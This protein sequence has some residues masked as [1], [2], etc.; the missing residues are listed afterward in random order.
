MSRGHASVQGRRR[1]AARTRSS[2]TRTSS[3]TRRGCPVPGAS[4]RCPGL[5]SEDAMPS[6]ASVWTSA[7]IVRNTL[8][9][10]TKVSVLNTRASTTR[11]QL[12][13][14]NSPAGSPATGPR[15]CARTSSTPTRARVR[16]RGGGRLPRHHG[17]VRRGRRQE[18]PTQADPVAGAVLAREAPLDEHGLAPV[19]LPK[20]ATGVLGRRSHLGRSGRGLAPAQRA[21]QS[22]FS[23]RACDAGCPASGR[24]AL[25]TC[26][27]AGL[28]RNTSSSSPRVRAVSQ[29][30]RAS[31]VAMSRV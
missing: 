6:R 24:N 9:I 4:T 20:E 10:E 18:D 30:R 11:S 17:V 26:R 1:P 21:A 15:T 23:A 19:R 22:T 27:Y 16:A 14:F 7:R 29:A 31:V 5:D 2:S 25:R 3:T 13:R 8:T 12:R 28:T